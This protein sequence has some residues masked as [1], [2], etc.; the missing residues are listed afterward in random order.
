MKTIGIRVSP[1]TVTFAIF[2]DSNRE[3]VNVEEL[4]VPAALSWPE[5][6]TYVRYN[7]LDIMRVY[8]VSRAGIRETEPTAK[9]PNSKR[10]QLEAVIQEA[11]ASARIEKFRVVQIASLGSLLQIPRDQVKPMIQGNTSP[12]FASNWSE[13][14]LEQREAILTAMGVANA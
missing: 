7:L 2:D 13:W 14:S 8:E 1:K 3:I 11:F 9:S 10:L 5:S 12:E 6:L 4:K